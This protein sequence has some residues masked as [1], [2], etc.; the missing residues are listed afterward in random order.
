MPPLPGSARP[1]LRSGNFFRTRR[2]PSARRAGRARGRWRGAAAP[3]RVNEAV[4]WRGVVTF[5]DQDKVDY[6]LTEAFDRNGA[7]R[8]EGAA[9]ASWGLGPRSGS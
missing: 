4:F 3:S 9:G 1:S 5:A 6:N 7:Y 2:F 8:D